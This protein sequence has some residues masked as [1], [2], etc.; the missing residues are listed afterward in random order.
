[1]ESKSTGVAHSKNKPVLYV[2]IGPAGSGKSTAAKNLFQ[3]AFRVCPDSIRKEL[4]GDEADQREP[5]KV[6]ATAYARIEDA[7]CY[8]FSVVFD[9]TNTTAFARKKV[10]DCVDGIVCRKVAVYMNTPLE[11]CKRRNRARGR[12]VPDAVIN[13]QY[14]QMLREA[15]S[16]PEQFDEIMIVEGW[17]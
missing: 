14:A 13:R 2:M 17:K 8:G 9:A 1:M 4:F 16:I 3:N 10:L 12:V 7:M 6:F 5:E 15:S 11:E